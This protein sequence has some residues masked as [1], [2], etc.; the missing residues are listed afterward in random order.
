MS[1][2]I[3]RIP[4]RRWYLCLA[5]AAATPAGADNPDITFF[6]LGKKDHYRQDA[7]GNLRFLS[8]FFFTD[9]VGTPHGRIES[10][11]L[12]PPGGGTPLAFPPLQDRKSSLGIHFGERRW[13]DLAF[14]DGDYRLDLRTP[15]GEV[16][17]LVVTLGGAALPPPAVI[18]LKQRGQPASID[19]IDPHVDLTIAWTPFT[20]GRADRNP[21]LEDIIFVRVH[22]CHNRM[23]AFSG[24]PRDPG[25]YLNFR[26]TEFTVAASAL[27]PGI[28]Y[29]MFVEPAIIADADNTT[30]IFALASYAPTTYLDF[31]TGGGAPADACPAN[32]PR[33]EPGMTDR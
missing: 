4:M 1:A 13:L 15:H 6:V 17:G 30:G 26:D 24:R 3:A 16:K 10:A 28:R 11:V 25:G 33:L 14:P 19:S 27:A 20:A 9:I 8:Y 7:A 18:T 2:S 32:M 21:L 5:L 22:D 12:T 23:I 31:Q 29:A